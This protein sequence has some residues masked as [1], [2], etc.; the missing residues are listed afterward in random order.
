MWNSIKICEP[1]QIVVRF[2]WKSAPFRPQQ[3]IRVYRDLID[4]HYKAPCFDFYLGAKTKTQGHAYYRGVLIIINF[5]KMQKCFES[6]VDINYKCI[7]LRIPKNENAR[8]IG[9]G[10]ENIRE[11]EHFGGGLLVLNG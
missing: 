8:L 11:R 4:P 6:R 10:Y 2:F 3:V 1:V 7:Y 5:L 9:E